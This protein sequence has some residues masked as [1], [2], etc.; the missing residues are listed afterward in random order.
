MSGPVTTVVLATALFL[1]SLTAGFLV[2]FAAVV[3][4]GLKTLE[5][6]A[7]LRAFQVVDRVIQNNQPVF[8]LMWVGSIVALLA[9][10]VLGL[11]TLTGGDRVLLLAAAALYLGGVQLPT[12][13]IN[14]PLNNRVQKLK[15]DELDSA[16]L[17]EARAEF[18]PRW[19]RWNRIR[20]GLACA[21]VAL[22][23]ALLI[24]V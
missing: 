2:A 9:A 1:C 21:S 8:M 22:M 18:E 5:D 14:V 15:M 20:T 11:G 24:I 6:A 13:T 17:Q 16:A 4:P 10:L 12:I 3:M 19:N 23:T 7:Y